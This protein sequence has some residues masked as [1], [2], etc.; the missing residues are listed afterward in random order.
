MVQNIENPNSS[1]THKPTNRIIAK[2]PQNF[3]FPSLESEN[4]IQAI[5]YIF[6]YRLNKIILKFGLFFNH[7]F[8][9]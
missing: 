1:K 4:L 9:L 6:S 5:I 3:D 7:I 2:K 8:V